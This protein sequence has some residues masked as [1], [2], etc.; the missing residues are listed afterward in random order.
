MRKYLPY[1]LLAFIVGM[2]GLSH[3]AS[4]ASASPADLRYIDG[5]KNH[6]QRAIDLAKMAEGKASNRGL[7]NLAKRMMAD[8]QKEITQLDMWRKKWFGDAAPAAAQHATPGMDMS[9]LQ[10]ASGQQFDERFI[11]QMSM[12]HEQGV[13]MSEQ[14]MPQLEHRKLQ[15]FARKMISKQRQEIEKMK[16]FKKS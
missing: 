10:R 12:H 5:M 14:A 4:A 13:Q 9:V 3:A 15:K 16:A 11:E 2:S 8:Q 1:I 7:R 6:H